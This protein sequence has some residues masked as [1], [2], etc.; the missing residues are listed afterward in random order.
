MKTNCFAWTSILILL[1]TV[2]VLC[3]CLGRSPQTKFYLLHSVD[4][5]EATEVVKSKD[6]L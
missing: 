6:D 2:L 1:T 3:G 4:S 5:L